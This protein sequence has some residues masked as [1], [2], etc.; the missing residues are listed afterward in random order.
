M[1]GPFDPVVD[2]DTGRLLTEWFEAPE[3][4][5]DEELRQQGCE[6][7]GVEEY[8]SGSD[9]T[10]EQ[11][12][13]MNQINAFVTH[14][15]NRNW[16]GAY[17]KQEIQVRLNEASKFVEHQKFLPA[18]VQERTGLQLNPLWMMETLVRSGVLTPKEQVGALKELASYTHSKAP[19]IN[20]STTTEMRPEDWLLE[21][22]KEEY[23]V[24]DITPKK[25]KAGPGSH[26]M[27]L[28]KK[29][30]EAQRI[31]NLQEF[32]KSE[33]QAV[34]SEIADADFEEYS[35]GGRTEI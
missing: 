21:L 5:T 8:P 11:R 20:H 35:F 25:E 28:S 2:E 16:P 7:Y 1:T 34:E 4:P 23:Q 6:K 26:P 19:S 18:E 17:T 24:V 12:R 27:Y 15:K 30:A 10:P 3:P 13:V 29:R 33:L 14:R 22:A 31:N 9:L 32:Q